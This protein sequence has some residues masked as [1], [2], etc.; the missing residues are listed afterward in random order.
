MLQLITGSI[1]LSLIHVAVPSHWLPIAVL[2]KSEKWTV[3]ETMLITLLAGLAHAIGTILL[4]LVIG[5]IGFKM[6]G[7]HAIFTEVISPIVLILMGLVYFA[8]DMHEHSHGHEAL[9][10]KKN[11]TK[12]SILLT[13][14]T[15]MFFSPC[16][17]IESIY[18]SAG[19][20][21]WKALTIVSIAY[22]LVTVL[23]MM[24]L[25]WLA[26]TGLKKWNWHAFEHYERKITGFILIVLGILV[27][28]TGH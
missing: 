17:E 23:G 2:G 9:E 11:R 28:F 14:T 27:Y 20:F 6:S 26:F 22:L 18:L 10:G 15:S 19:A 21:G 25:V 5:F 24:L 13:L 3:R 12:T 4:G 8:M 1:I 7:E 16:L